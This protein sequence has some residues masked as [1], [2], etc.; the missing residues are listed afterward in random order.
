MIFIF[1][2]S[3]KSGT[4]M[5]SKIF[6]SAIINICEIAFILALNLVIIQMAIAISE[7]PIIF[8]KIK[9]F[10]FPNISPTII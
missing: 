6:I 9:A 10:S 3:N 7:K 5:N 2:Q 1:P 8:V 4:K